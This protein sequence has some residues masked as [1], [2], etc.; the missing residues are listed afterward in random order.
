MEPSQFFRRWCISLQTW[1]F[2]TLYS[3]RLVLRV[4]EKVNF[5]LSSLKKPLANIKVAI[6]KSEKLHTFDPKFV[7]DLRMRGIKKRD[8]F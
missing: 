1:F 2:A 3:P 4:I 8:L 5:Q 7:H 6:S